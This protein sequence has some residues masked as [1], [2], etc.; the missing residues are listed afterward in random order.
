LHTRFADRLEVNEDLDRSLVSFQANKEEPFYRWFR[1]KEGFSSRLVRYLLAHTGRAKGVMLDPFAGAGAALFAARDMGWNVKGIELLPVGFYAM[2]ARQCIEEVDLRAARAYLERAERVPSFDACADETH[3]FQHIRI[4]EGAFPAATEK[5]L[6]GW[7]AFCEKE[8]ADRAVRRL[9]Q[10]A[11]FTILEEISYTRKDGQYLRWDARSARRNGGT[12]FRKPRIRRFRFAVLDKL[13]AIL[14]DLSQQQGS[15][16]GAPPRRGQLDIRRG[17]CLHVLPEVADASVDAVVTSPPYCNRYDYTRTYALELA[18]LGNS[19]DDVKALRQKLLSCTVENR[20]KDEEL[21]ELYKTRDAE[22]V[23]EEVSGVFEAQEALAEI[24][25]ALDS[26]RSAGE[27]NN[28]NVPRMVRNYF[29]EMCFVIRELARVLRPGGYVFMVNDN[30]RYAGEEIP[31]DLILSDVAAAFGLNVERIWVL[32]RGK[33]NSSQQMGTH[34]R[35]ELRKCVYA[36]R[37]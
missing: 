27:L 21:R 24:L 15:L 25:G 35:R 3:R 32:P 30:V 37:K 4:T 16:L 11:C 26:Y 2:T 34:G 22:G 5:E 36:W 29:Y 1:F 8:V 28:T 20:S 10:F 18:F 12:R 33:G 7:L 19:D 31:A 17:S 9:F 6:D 14:R 23:L 13:R